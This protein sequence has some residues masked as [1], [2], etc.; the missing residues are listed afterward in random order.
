[1]A[2]VSGLVLDTPPV[3]ASSPVTVPS[4]SFM[5]SWT[6]TTLALLESGMHVPG[7]PGPVDRSVVN[8]PTPNDVRELA[9]EEPMWVSHYSASRDRSGYKV[10]IGN[11]PPGTVDDDM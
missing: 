4:D 6:P 11:L 7:A 5:F 3:D 10:Y 2:C 8:G 9:F 1:M